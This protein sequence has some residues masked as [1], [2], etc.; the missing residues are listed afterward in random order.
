[1]G[2]EGLGSIKIKIKVIFGEIYI[3]I[4]NERSKR[5]KCRYKTD[6]ISG[7]SNRESTDIRTGID[8]PTTYD[9]TDIQSRYRLDM[10]YKYEIYGI[11]H[12]PTQCMSRPVLGGLH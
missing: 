2:Q 10:N 12:H 9:H 5:I 11:Q 3:L 4:H 6:C 7:E 1:M 8:I